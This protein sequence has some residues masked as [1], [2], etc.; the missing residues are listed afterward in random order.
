MKIRAGFVSN[1]SCSSFIIR[2]MTKEQAIDYVKR[3][4]V[5]TYKEMEWD[6]R[7]P[8]DEDDPVPCVEYEFRRMFTSG[9]FH[10]GSPVEV[11]T[12]DYIK[13]HGNTMGYPKT[14]IEVGDVIFH[15]GDQ[16]IPIAML[17]RLRELGHPVFRMD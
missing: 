3:L 1:S 5:K 13:K 9:W 16:E 11:V 17:D 7:G 10:H 2:L 12:E 8:I 4:I 6:L 14:T 15:G